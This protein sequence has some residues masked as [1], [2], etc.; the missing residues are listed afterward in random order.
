MVRP[1]T[2]LSATKK[3][4]LMKD[5]Q[6]KFPELW[7]KVYVQTDEYEMP[8]F[9]SMFASARCRQ[10]LTPEDADLV[11]FGGG[12]DVDPLFYGEKPHHT[13]KISP[14][15]DSSDL[16]LYK[17]C[18]DLGIPM[19]GVC[20]GA[21]FLHVMNG[22]K[23]FQDVD[24]HYGEHTMWD[25]KNK[26]VLLGVS[27]VHHQ[28]CI[29][30]TEGGMDIIAEAHT[31]SKRWLNPDKCE[32]GHKRDLEAFFYRDTC[33]F[34]VQ[35]HP[36]YSGY[37]EFTLWALKMIEDL[38]ICNPDVKWTGNNLRILPDLLEQRQKGW[39][40]KKGGP[41]LTLASNAN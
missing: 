33:A 21:Q 35:G 19:F 41:K 20:R 13:T 16:A 8:S 34:G 12:P 37:P 24:G 2:H 39:S 18:L 22:G 23:L 32:S 26:R 30:N 27:S 1:N 31:S 17:K 9:A 40:T 6:L 5:T 11:V 25:R 28:M 10:A 36:E 15:R 29:A 7:I 3:L 4:V 14:T 38:I